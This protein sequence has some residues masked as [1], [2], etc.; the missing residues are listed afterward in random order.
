MS[1]PKLYIKNDKGRY[2]P[3]QLPEPDVSDTVYRKINGKYCERRMTCVRYM[4]HKKAVL[5][6]Y[7]KPLP[8]VV[9]KFK[10]E[11]CYKKYE[12]T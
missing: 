3:Y 7:N 5:E 8:Y 1:K 11:E 12:Q 6:E 2:E 4:L 10:F 9:R